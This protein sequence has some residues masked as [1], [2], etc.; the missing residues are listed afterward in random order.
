M[1]KRSLL[2]TRINQRKLKK[3]RKRASA[4]ASHQKLI[5]LTSSPD[6]NNFR[7]ILLK[8]EKRAKMTLNLS[9]SNQLIS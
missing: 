2:K 7:V 5:F 9:N 3:R 1:K 6:F 8:R 4:L